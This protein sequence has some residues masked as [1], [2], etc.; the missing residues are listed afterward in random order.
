MLHQEYVSAAMGHLA[1]AATRLLADQD[2]TGSHLMVGIECLEIQ[3][4]LGELSAE[5][6]SV[7]AGT[8]PGDALL[9]AA[10]LLNQDG[11][12]VLRTLADR[13]RLLAEG[14]H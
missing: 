13:L 8:A 9:R 5:V 6:A 7:A 14:V 11:R 1:L 3:S 2:P 10:D 12:A 4:L